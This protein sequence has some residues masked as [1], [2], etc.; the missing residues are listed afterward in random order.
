MSLETKITGAWNDLLQRS[1]E[2]SGENANLF[3]ILLQTLAK[4]RVPTDL[5]SASRD[6]AMAAVNAAV[7]AAF[8][9]PSDVRVEAYGSF[10]SGLFSPTS[11]LDL[12]LIGT[13]DVSALPSALHWG[14]FKS[15]P[16]S[17]MVAMEE[18]DKPCRV[19][20]LQRLV[21]QLEGSSG[22][23]DAAAVEGDSII[24]P[25]T[26]EKIF[27]AR[28]PIVKFIENST[29]V[30]CDICVASRGCAF[31]AETI[32]ALAALDGRF[33]D[34]CRLIKLWAKTHRMNDAAFGTF[35]SFALMLM[36]M[37]SLQVCQPAVLPPMWQA[38][39]DDGPPD[40]NLARL[41]QDP[42]SDLAT[43]L[44]QCQA[45][46]EQWRGGH[47]RPWEGVNT[48]S[49]ME[50]FTWFLTLYACIAEE[51]LS[52]GKNRLYR[53]SPWLGAGW[54][55]GHR[56]HYIM[57]VEDPFDHADNTARTVGSQSAHG[58]THGYILKVLQASRDLLLAKEMSSV[59]D[60]TAAFTWLFGTEATLEYLPTPAREQLLALPPGLAP[61][62]EQMK[63]QGRST[64]DVYKVL[65]SECGGPAGLLCYED[66]QQARQVERQVMF[67][68]WEETK[69]KQERQQQ[70]KRMQKFQERLQQQQQQQQQQQLMRLAQ[71]QVP[72]Q[73][74]QQTS[75]QMSQQHGQPSMSMNLQGMHQ[76]IIASTPQDSK[77]PGVGQSPTQSSVEMQPGQDAPAPGNDLY[78]L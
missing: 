24:R 23:E 8:P 51:W 69:M 13:L 66:W 73:V 33:A 41:L 21:R 60:V 48:N 26:L 52:G 14:L 78:A 62:L 35:N 56:V 39:S 1:G 15:R 55:R 49:L 2:W 40:P 67:K 29:G 12:S 28:V 38:F 75:Q 5:H 53:V 43:A 77:H 9:P 25:G 71:Q 3:N 42:A 59:Q 61:R 7:Q 76:G 22:S 57:Y 65:V 63:Q 18:L 20:V 47:S 72:Q 50:L 32:R 10:V 58:N 16:M 19:E 74:S 17:D 44:K 30:E 4:S 54:L 36:A 68:K 31:K 45:R 11:D 64:T 6:A 70:A 34:L 37:F 27:A 46:C